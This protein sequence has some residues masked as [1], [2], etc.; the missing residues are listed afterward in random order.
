MSDGWIACSRSRKCPIC[1]KPDWCSVSEDG[2]TVH[3]HR[4]MSDHP[5]ATGYIH[6]VKP[7]T[8]PI[9]RNPVPAIPNVGER[10]FSAQLYW[11]R[12]DDMHDTYGLDGLAVELGV[13]VDALA[14]LQ[15]RYGQH[16][17]G[18][19]TEWA[20]AWPMRDG[21]GRMVGIR[22]RNSD[23]EKWAVKYSRQ[24]LFYDTSI[25]SAEEVMVLE[26]PTDTSAAMTLGFT[27]VGRPSCMGCHEE[28][29]ALFKRWR[30]RRMIVVAD[31]DSPKK[32][33]DGS[34]WYPG[35]DG[36]IRL[37]KAMGV[38]YRM[39]MTPPKDIRKW[40][41]QGAT[42]KQVDDVIDMLIWRLPS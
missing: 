22:L 41:C 35:R 3:C 9:V 11:Q 38:E 12:L 2:T 25:T 4:V 23:G 42:R 26:G 7:D 15:P 21:G 27:A 16:A 34:V 24:G 30:T 10:L 31:N 32:R 20:W 28:L 39:L 18:D 5:T 36:A 17:R 13:D 8:A 1:G 6:V 14:R 29:K 19:E 40:V 37:V 33:P